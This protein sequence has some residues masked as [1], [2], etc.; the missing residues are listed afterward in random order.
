MPVMPRI[1]RAIP[2]GA[3]TRPEPP[4][5]PVFA[6]LRWHDGRDTDVPAIATAWTRDAVEIAWEAPGLGL[7]S[8]WIPAADV[9]RTAVALKPSLRPPDSRG[10]RMRAG[11]LIGPHAP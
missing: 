6:I 7:R 9:R 5:L 8:D 10:R 1:M 11:G 4:G 2:R 3:I